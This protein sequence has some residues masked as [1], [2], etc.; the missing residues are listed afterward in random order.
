MEKKFFS[1]M[2]VLLIASLFFLGCPTDGDDDDTPP[3]SK[4]EAETLV[5]DLGGKATVDGKVVTLT[6]DVELAKDVTIPNDVTLKI[7]AGKTLT[8]PKDR[9]LTVTGTLNGAD[10]TSKLKVDADATVTGIAAGKTYVWDDTSWLDETVYTAAKSLA[11]NAA[12]TG[13]ATRT[14]ATV[15]LSADVTVATTNAATVAE[16]V[17][18]VTGAHE[19]NVTGAFP[20]AGTITVKTGGTLKV[21]ALDGTGQPVDT[22]TITYTGDGKVELEQGAKAYYGNSLFLFTDNTGL[23]KWDTD[24]NGSKVTLKGNNVTEL[25]AG[26]VTARA[27]TGIATN[28]SIVVANGATLTIADSVNYL[29]WGTLTVKDGGTLKAPALT[30]AQGLPLTGASVVNKI[31]FPDANGK[32]ELEQG[33]SGYYGSS[34]FV[35]GGNTSLYTW[36]ADGTNSKVTLKPGNVTQVDGKVTA[37]AD[38]GIAQT[39]SI[40][41]GQNA[42]LTIAVTVNF[43]IWGELTGSSN[44]TLVNNGNI[45]LQGGASSNFYP[46]ASETAITTDPITTGTYK[47]NAAAGGGS[48]AGWKAQ[49]TP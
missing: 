12:F 10:T 33:A 31:A 37:R 25:T 15:T 26:K 29:I 1:G 23:Y 40:V 18:L 35:S 3:P 2:A 28:T 48:T 4:S 17:T 34:Y 6:D 30:D 22:N 46:N 19:L 47:W 14:G 38:T 49:P 27:D 20:V 8:V 42:T 7:D 13:K 9:T 21:P 36:D 43:P 24:G 16:G 41:V 39:T 11:E 5:D 32:V 45:S 44:A